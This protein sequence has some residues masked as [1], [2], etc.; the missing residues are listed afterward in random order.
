MEQEENVRQAKEGEICG[1]VRK[2]VECFESQCLCVRRTQTARTDPK[3]TD[4][5]R[6]RRRDG[7]PIPPY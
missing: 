5:I 2:D 4:L 7:R 6:E 1:T 3:A